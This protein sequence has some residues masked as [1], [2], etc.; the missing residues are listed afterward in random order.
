MLEDKIVVLG[1]NSFAGAAFVAEALRRQ[2]QVFGI[3][4]SEEPNPVFL[5]YQPQVNFQFRQLDLNQN[6]SQIIEVLS[7]FRPEMIVDFAGQGMVAESWQSPEQWYQTNII[8]KVRL[9][10]WLKDQKWLKKYIRISTPEVYGSCDTL[11]DESRHYTPST[12]YAVS[13]ASIDMSL[14]A[15]YQQYDFPVVIGRFANFYGEHQQ[16][17]R[18]IPKTIL[19]ILSHKKLP[20]HGGGKSVRAFIHAK[21]VAQGIFS[22][23]KCGAVGEVYHFS[24]TYFLAIRDVVKLICDKLKVDF[25]EAVEISPDR[26]G[27]DQ[28][29]LMSSDKSRKELNW[30]PKV[31]FEE[32]LESTINWISQN[33]EVLSGMSWNYAHKS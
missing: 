19:S 10:N 12:P 1:S 6:L 28:A 33:F 3:S 23:I 9:H 17:Y 18:I 24:P 21:D 29:Y 5:P 25:E 13:H 14:K 26:P 30:V 15:F 11:I 22:M 27:K 7:F 2:H 31:S 32:G 4:R 20:L 8:S 16:L